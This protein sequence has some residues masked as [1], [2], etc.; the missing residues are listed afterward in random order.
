MNHILDDEEY[1]EIVSDIINNDEFDK[2]KKIEH[3]GTTRYEHSL[4]VSYR[5]YKIAKFLKLNAYETAR[6]GLLHDFFIS[7]NNQSKLDKC[8]ST[9]T[10]PYK[11]VKTVSKNFNVSD[12]ELDIIKTHMF[13]VNLSI[14][15]YAESWVVNLVDKC[16]GTYEFSVKFGNKFDYAANLAVVL[17]MNI[18][19]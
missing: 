17:F 16:I 12:R 18:M 13:P 10:H 9:F 2:I 11:A 14:P 1:Y 15:R 6:A 7:S 3:H 8:I 5:A 19:K 4:K